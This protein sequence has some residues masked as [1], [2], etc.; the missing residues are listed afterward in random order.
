MRAVHT[1]TAGL[2]LVLAASLT[3]RA[4]EATDDQKTLQ[5]TWD[6]VFLERNGGEV[7]PQKNTTMT[8]SDDTFVV[9]I[10]DRVIAA[11]TFKLETGKS[12]KLAEL[13]YTEGLDSEKGK[14]FKGIY[15]LEGN[16]WTFCR[17][18]S[19]DQGPPAEF[20]TKA[21]TGGFL[22]VYEKRAK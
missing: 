12:P 13:S 4:A 11:G 21:D 8:F 19:P 5:G 1:L 15:K 9:K 6:I 2:V 20:K 14:T 18:R 17:G 3:T 22:A 7:K 10:G 16:R